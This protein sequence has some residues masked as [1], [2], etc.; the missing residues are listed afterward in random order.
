MRTATALFFTAGLLAALGG[1][2]DERSAPGM[3]ITSDGR[4]LSNSATTAQGEAER[5]ITTSLEEALGRTWTVATTIKELPN[6]REN[7]VGGGEWVWESCTADVVLTGP[8]AS[9]LPADEIKAGVVK[10]LKKKMRHGEAPLAVMVKIQTAA[11]AAPAV[12]AVPA[13]SPVSTPAVG[14]RTYKIQPGDTLAD[15]STLHFG[16]TERWRDILAANPGVTADH[17]VPGQVLVIP[18]R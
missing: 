16:S 7:A 10:Y 5:S 18:T 6:Y 4:F 3:V 11:V 14:P 1:C 15:I 17:L 9:P 12:P 8:G 2:G 13:T